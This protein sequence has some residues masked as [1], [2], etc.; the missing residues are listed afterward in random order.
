MAG[1]A[2]DDVAEKTSGNQPVG[3]FVR[4]TSL[5][6]NAISKVGPFPPAKGRYLLYVSYACPWASRCVALRLMKGLEDVI[7]LAVVTAEWTKTKVDDENDQHRGWY[8][9]ASYPG[10]TRDPVWDC[11]TIRDV[12]EKSVEGVENAPKTERF[13]VPILFDKQ[14]KRIVN[15]ESGEILRFLAAEFNEFAKYP[16]LDTYPAKFRTEIDA[17]NESI[18]ESI[19]NGVYKCGFAQ[20]QEAYDVA[21]EPLFQRLEE[22][23][24]I[25]EKQRYL[26]GG[27]AGLTEA[28][29][30]LFVTLVR[31]DP[32]YFIHFKCCKKLIREYKNLGPWLRDVYQTMR[33]QDSVNLKHIRDHYYMC[34][35]SIN[36]FGIVPLVGVDLESPHGRDSLPK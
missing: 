3:A 13:T 17:M 11:R 28:D 2:L 20:T 6:R 33:L 24:T 15:N 36:P 5:F 34:H 18:Y 26:I 32:V 25:L 21:K 31:Y 23:D 9:D 16:E 10:G 7:D 19:N 1:T 35:K 22:L 4:K 14:T 8:F 30:R 29:I 27:G 12:Y